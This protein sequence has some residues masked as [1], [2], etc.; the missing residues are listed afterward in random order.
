MTG[1][2][3]KLNFTT[4]NDDPKTQR[5]TPLGQVCHRN[6]FY[7]KCFTGNGSRLLFA[8]DFDNGNLNYYM[9][10]L[11]NGEAVQ[12]TEGEGDNTFGGFLSHDDKFL[13]YV[14]NNKVLKRLNLSDFTEDDVYISSADW[15]SYGT[16]VANSE[17]DKIVGIE[18]ARDD[19]MPLKSW[20]EFAVM[21]HNK[22]RC[23]LFT[24]N[25][26]NGEHKTIHEENRWLG[27]PT[28]RPFDDKTLS[29]CHEGPHDLVKSRIWFVNADGT[30]MRQG[31]VQEEDEHCTHEFWVPDGS[32]MI[33][34]S[35]K[36]HT[37]E[38]FIYSVDP[39]TLQNELIMPM[40]NCSHLMS[41]YDGSLLVGD[42]TCIP[43]DVADQSKYTFDTDNNLYLFDTV[44]KKQTVLTAHKTS[45]SVW[46]GSRQMTHPHPSFSP[47]DRHV[48]WTSDFE[49]QPS[50]YLTTR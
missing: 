29:F 1:S 9:L 47:A 50:L 13:Y 44:N 42:G 15:V 6:Y 19:W 7:Q 2:I 31:K 23:R 30:N 37:N 11:Q 36:E 27:H 41:N 25:L 21:Y 46:N 22:P 3:V 8:G 24:A 16:W 14:K 18:I 33:Y 34:V 4:L 35:F 48:L 32:K 40:P 17:T 20:E 43:A 49:G 26:E 12:L 38:R 10:N 39:D 28:Y 45:W 5:L